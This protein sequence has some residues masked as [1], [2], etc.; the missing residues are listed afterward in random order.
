M[1]DVVHPD[2]Q[3]LLRDLFKRLTLEGE[4]AAETTDG[5]TPFVVVRIP[6][7]D[8]PFIVPLDRTQPAASPDRVRAPTR[9]PC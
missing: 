8:E 5:A 7:F 6:G 4:V 3:A 2:P 9:F 1:I